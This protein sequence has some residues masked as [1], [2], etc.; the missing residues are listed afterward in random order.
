MIEEI[1]E[2]YVKTETAGGI[3]TIEFFH[4]Q[5]NSL[6][7]AILNAL[8]KAI[9]AEGLNETTKVI[10]LRSA[11]EKIFCAGASF[12][13]L[14]SITT[15]EQGLQFFSGFAHV[16]NAMRKAPKF[17]IVR[18]QGKC[19]GGGVGL[20]AAADY[21][22][23]AE[24]SDIKLS[25]LALGIG[26]FV[27]GPAVERKLGT[28]AFSQLAID[29]SM[30]RSADWA[31]RKGLFA[32][33]HADIAGVDDSITR[34]SNTLSNS[35]PEAMHE[36]KKVLWKGTDHWD[37]LLLERAGISGTLILSEYS[38][39]FIQKFKAAAAQKSAAK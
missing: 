34:L 18:I 22:I 2:G 29:A 37:E 7:G 23:A 28:S 20:A 38:K 8:A 11:G 33:L 13:E 24:G 12:D 39:T 3:A 4:P 16:I 32:E 17:I 25:E 1:K 19:I 27:V 30:W 35:S 6:P 5:S 14:A 31:R 9:H 36:L 26:P 21:A 10:I 15:E